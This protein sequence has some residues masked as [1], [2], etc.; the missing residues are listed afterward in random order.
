MLHARN[1]A[2]RAPARQMH[3]CTYRVSDFR[4]R[5]VGLAQV[6]SD[7]VACDNL[8]IDD[9]G[10]LKAQIRRLGRSACCCRHCYCAAEDPPD[11][12]NAT[13]QQCGE[14][15]MPLAEL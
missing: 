11:L 5:S 15:D 2:H 4:F 12:F 13:W 7:L 6:T 10:E 9:F 8:I 14:F 3:R 1:C